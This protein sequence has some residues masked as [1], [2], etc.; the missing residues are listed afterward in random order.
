MET[1]IERPENISNNHLNIV[2]FDMIIISKSMCIND[3]STLANLKFSVGSRE[4]N[5][6]AVWRYR[7]ASMDKSKLDGEMYRSLYEKLTQ[8]FTWLKHF[9]K[10]EVLFDVQLRHSSYTAS[11]RLPSYLVELLGD[12]RAAVVFS[13]YPT[14]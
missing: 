1:F 13:A 4:V 3:I 12:F 14:N 10:G 6:S 5:E 9:S 11:L 8:E 2:I 7:V